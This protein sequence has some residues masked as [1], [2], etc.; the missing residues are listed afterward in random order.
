MGTGLSGNGICSFPVVQPYV[1]PPFVYILIMA[2]PLAI[3]WTP[4]LACDLF[5]DAL[6]YPTIGLLYKLTRIPA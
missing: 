2:V 6:S 3:V 5:Y 4:G 1:C